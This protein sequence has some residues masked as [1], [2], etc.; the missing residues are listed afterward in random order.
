MPA[1]CPCLQPPNL[2]APPLDDMEYLR[3]RPDLQIPV[4]VATLEESNAGG[5]LSIYTPEDD[6]KMVGILLNDTYQCKASACTLNMSFD[7]V[8]KTFTAFQF[9]NELMIDDS[10]EFLKLLDNAKIVKVAIKGSKNKQSYTFDNS[11]Q[12]YK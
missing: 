5:T 12:D 2:L 10:K 9:Q 11:T 7:N 8:K 1:E 4:Q 3:R 6:K